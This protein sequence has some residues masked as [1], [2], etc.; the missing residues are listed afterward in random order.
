[1]F[2]NTKVIAL[3]LLIT[4][5]SINSQEDKF[6]ANNL[7]MELTPAN[8][9][10]FV[11]GYFKGIELF[12]DVATNST[13]IQNAEIITEGAITLFNVLRDL[14]VDIHIV[15][16]VTKIVKA[17]QSI[18]SS[19]KSE[20]SACRAAGSLAM[21]DVKRLMERLSRDGYVKELAS[22]SW[23]NASEIAAMLASGADSYTNEKIQEAGLAFGKA[24]KFVA[25]WDL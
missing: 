17:V 5:V 3:I 12:E 6:L 9:E 18:M 21:D 2:K 22:H 25:F 16:N 8:A 20:D 23:S 14:K 7:E 13:C 24:T 10:E 1:M 11:R 15:S 19:I 4:L